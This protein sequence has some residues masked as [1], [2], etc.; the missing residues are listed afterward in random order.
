[1][2]ERLLIVVVV[3]LVVVVAAL[4][5]RT[6]ARQ[7]EAAARGRPLSNEVRKRF[8]S[9]SPGILY[10]FGP[11]CATCRRQSSILDTLAQKDGVTVVGVDAVA[12]AGI[13]DEIG[14]LTVPSTVI[15]DAAH[16]IRAV[17][18]GL[19]SRDAL[20]TQFDELAISPLQ[21]VE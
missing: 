12:E 21:S 3:T 10:F 19:R 18:T 20:A 1:M 6:A 8:R 4:A 17:N 16:T 14:I 9:G 15:I 13:A 5:V 2:L 7:R 11:H